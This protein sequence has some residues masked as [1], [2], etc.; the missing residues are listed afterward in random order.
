MELSP[1]WEADSPLDGQTIPRSLSNPKVHCRVRKRTPL[2]PIQSLP[3]PHTLSPYT[4]IWISSSFLR[5][6]L[7]SSH[8]PSYFPSKI[9]YVL[10]ISSM[11]ATCPTH[12]VLLDLISVEVRSPAQQLNIFSWRRVATTPPNPPVRWPPLVGCPWTPVRCRSY[13]L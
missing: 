5:L 3:N 4:S 2:V 13:P 6:G 1:S 8:I 12:F 11:R 7:P 10:F 9:L